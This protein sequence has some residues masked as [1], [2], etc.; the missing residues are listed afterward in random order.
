MCRGGR[1]SMGLQSKG[2]GG[3]KVIDQPSTLELQTV[4]IAVVTVCIVVMVAIADHSPP[5]GTGVADPERCSSVALGPS[6]AGVAYLLRRG[7]IDGK[8][9]NHGGHQHAGPGHISL[10][11]VRKS[12]TILTVDLLDRGKAQ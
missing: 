11:T 6:A 3:P 2:A 9:I 4:C 1:A 12:T 8:S 10:L 7:E 5:P